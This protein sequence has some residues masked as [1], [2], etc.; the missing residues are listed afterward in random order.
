[1]RD[2]FVARPQQTFVRVVLALTTV[3]FALQLAPS[4][5][6]TSARLLLARGHVLA[7]AIVIP[8]LTWAIRRA[9]RHL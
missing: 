2:S 6:T 5:T 1:M 8:G 3:W 9:P 4:H 7:A